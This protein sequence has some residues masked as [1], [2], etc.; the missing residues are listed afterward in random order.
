MSDETRMVRVL[1]RVP[2]AL[3]LY[4]AVLVKPY[5]I[6]LSAGFP[7]DVHQLLH[8]CILAYHALYWLPICD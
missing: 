6:F 3:G 1:F 2:R 8:A 5:L 4:R 7:L